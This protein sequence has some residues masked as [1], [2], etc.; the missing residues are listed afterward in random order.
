MR[1][2]VYGRQSSNKAKSIAEQIKAGHATIR[3][4]GWTHVGDYQDGRSASRFATKARDE[5]QQ[6]LADVKAAN[7]DVLILWESS[8]GDRTADT[9]LAFLTDCRRSNVRIYVIKD[10]RLYDLN[11]ARDRKTLAE[12]GIASEYESDLLSERV[13]RGHKGAAEAGLPP[14]GPVPFGYLRHFDPA[15]GKREGWVPDPATAPKVRDLFRRVGAGDPV[16][17]IGNDLNLSPNAVRRIAR[18]PLYLGIRVHNG[19][20][21]QGTWEP[22]VSV[23]VF[24][25]ARDVL[26]N[27][28]RRITRPGRQKHLLTYLA[29]CAVCGAWIEQAV[30]YYRCTASRCVSAPMADLDAVIDKVFRR[31]LD[32]PDALLAIAAGDDSEAARWQAEA[33]RL[34]QQITE[35][36]TIAGQGTDSPIRVAG[37]IRDLQARVR[38][39]EAAGRSAR[40]P[41]AARRALDRVGVEGSAWWDTA[42]TVARRQLVKGLAEI[43]IGRGIPGRVPSIRR[44]ERAFHRLGPSRWVGS[45]GTWADSVGLS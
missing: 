27:P 40:L 45:E 37:I 4:E 15:T 14:G 5:W 18:N 16:V 29:R 44:E 22:L 30:G 3:D 20:E 28:D 42:G 8:R 24:N 43:R 9:W 38:D 19:R 33:D 41:A 1:A 2:A 6:V 32:N 7:L 35:W 34:R 25:A 36:E 17:R 26:G 12:D 39:A 23:T 11:R 31:R 21:H 13:K 10:E